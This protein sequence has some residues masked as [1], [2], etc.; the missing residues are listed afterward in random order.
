MPLEVEV[1]LNFIIPGSP[2]HQMTLLQHIPYIY[3]G[4][5]GVTVMVTEH[6]TEHIQSQVNLTTEK[7]LIVSSILLIGKLSLGDGE[8]LCSSY[9]THK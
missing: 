1:C 7:V 8:C 6:Y 2:P 9:T 5:V 4:S 3:V